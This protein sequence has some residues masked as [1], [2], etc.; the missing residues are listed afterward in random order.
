MAIGRNDPCEC[1]SGR[2]YKA[3]CQRRNEMWARRLRAHDPYHGRTNALAECHAC[4]TRVPVG[5]LRLF[6]DMWVRG[7]GRRIGEPARACA[8]CERAAAEEEA[9]CRTGA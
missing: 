9:A 3:C 5:Q 2:K 6:P 1:G 7:S 8:S 4:G